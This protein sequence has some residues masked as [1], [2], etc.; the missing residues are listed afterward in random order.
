MTT[1]K[2]AFESFTAPT[3]KHAD[4]IIPRGAE[5]AVAIRLL[6]ELS[7]TTLR[8][9]ARAARVAAGGAAGEG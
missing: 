2:P 9:R 8:A 7:R 1:V 5:N 4:V 6:L 3:A